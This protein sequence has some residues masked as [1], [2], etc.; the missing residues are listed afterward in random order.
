[1]PLATGTFGEALEALKAGSKVARM[2]W[3]GRG[4]FLEL[5]RPTSKSKMTAPYI[6]IDTTGL[7]TDNPNAPKVL[8]P[9]LASQTDMLAEDWVEVF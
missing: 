7:D 4:I 6:Y 1:M 5:Q 3:N 9:W 8:V 2:G